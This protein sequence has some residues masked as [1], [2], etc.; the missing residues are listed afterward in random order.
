MARNSRNRAGVVALVSGGLDSLALV[1]T[2]LRKRAVVFPVYVRCGLSWEPAE[3]FWLRRWLRRVA[4]PDLKP[5]AILEVPV[6]SVYANHWSLTGRGI[7]S[8]NSPDV[9]VYL[10]GRNIFL[11]GVGAVHASS[12][13][14]STLALGILGGNPF[15]DAQPTFFR[16]FAACVSQALSTPI[17]IH[18][19]L[20]RSTKARLVTMARQEPL[21]LTFSCLRPRGRRHCGRCNKCAERRRAFRAARIPDPTHYAR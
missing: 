19:P 10:P 2:L 18:T 11:L 14:L 1:Q 5:L 15:G 9:A 8:A 16:R 4:H 3:L 7:P 20:R 17:R 6:R 13:G 21:R 12:H